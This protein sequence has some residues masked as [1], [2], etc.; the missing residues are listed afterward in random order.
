MPINGGR[1]SEEEAD[2]PLSTIR[3]ASSTGAR[4]PN[5]AIETNMMASE[6]TP[7]IGPGRRRL[8]N[9]LAD[10]GRRGTGGTDDVALNAM[11]HLVS[12]DLLESDILH[13]ATSS[14]AL[15]G[16]LCAMA[17]ARR[18]GTLVLTG[19]QIEPEQTLALLAQQRGLTGFDAVLET[20]PVLFQR[21]LQQQ[22]VHAALLG[23]QAD[24]LL[25]LGGGVLPEPGG[26]SDAGLAPQEPR[27]R[28]LP[29]S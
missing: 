17:A 22:Q 29:K 28:F 20:Q 18:V 3:T 19:G 23:A 27:L 8:K 9:G 13:I 4:K 15:L 7:G 5:Q 24:L 12:G 1:G 16:N 21:Q 6:K 14:R 11:G 2:I 10:Q 26:P 25:A